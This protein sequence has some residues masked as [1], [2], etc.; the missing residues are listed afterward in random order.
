MTDFVRSDLYVAGPGEAVKRFVEKVDSSP[1][2]DSWGKPQLLDFRAYV[3]PPAGMDTS[4]RDNAAWVDENWGKETSNALG[5]VRQEL[6]DGSCLFIFQT[7][8]RAPRLWLRETAG[9]HPELLFEMNYERS[10]AYGETIVKTLRHKDGKEQEGYSVFLVDDEQPDWPSAARHLEQLEHDEELVDLASGRGIELAD[11]IAEAL[12]QLRRDL[13]AVPPAIDAAPTASFVRRIW[14]QEQEEHLP[15][16]AISFLV[17]QRT[18]WR[19]ELRTRTEEEEAEREKLEAE[20]AFLIDETK[21]D[22]I[23]T[24][25]ADKYPGENPEM[26]RALNIVDRAGRL[27][28]LRQANLTQD[29]VEKTLPDLGQ[30]I[31]RLAVTDTLR[32]AKFDSDIA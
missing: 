13:A 15:R 1:E 20:I 12:E 24:F 30:A 23:L 22:E 18:D 31:G 32:A 7:T 11:Q 26:K 28:G 25:F 16:R 21:Q 2:E 4:L 6:P 17:G 9:E 5:T 29:E 19:E 8:W 27:D 10:P 3:P 14:D